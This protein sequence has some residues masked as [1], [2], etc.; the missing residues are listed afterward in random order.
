M[1]IEYSSTF[2]IT[3]VLKGEFDWLSVPHK[4]SVFVK[5][6]KN[7]HLR[8]HKADEAETKHTCLG[9]SP[10]YKLCVFFNPVG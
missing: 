7:L 5:M 10:L 2:H 8:N 4:G 1:F 6:F 3:F 9:H